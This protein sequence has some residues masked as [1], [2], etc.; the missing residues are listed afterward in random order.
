LL[1][2][3]L[4]PPG[5]KTTEILDELLGSGRCQIK[6]FIKDNHTSHSYRGAQRNA[7]R[8]RRGNYPGLNRY[9]SCLHGRETP[10][11]CNEINQQITSGGVANLIDNVIGILAYFGC[12]LLNRCP[13]EMDGITRRLTNIVR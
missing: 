5:V 9:H 1:L 4:L 7:T 12:I 10:S 11:D 3:L 8:L 13:L 6:T 2:L